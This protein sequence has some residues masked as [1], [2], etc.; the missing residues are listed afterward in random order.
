MNA[1]SILA[2]KKRKLPQILSSAT[3]AK[4]ERLK[5]NAARRFSNRMQGE[6]LRGKG[7]TSTEFADYRSYTAGDDI[8]NVDWNI[9]SRLRKPYVKQFHVE[10]QTQITILIDASSSM[11]FDGKFERAREIA[12][13]IGIMGL[14]NQERVAAFAWGGEHGPLPALTP[15]AGRASLRKLLNFCEGIEGGG[16]LAIEQGVEDMLYQIKGRGIILILSD[17]LTTGELKPSFN[18]LYANGLEIMGLQILSPEEI[19]PDLTGDVRLIDCETRGELDISSAG[20]LINLYQEYREGYAKYLE[21][22]CRQRSGR[23][24]TVSSHDT[25]EQIVF[26]QMRRKGWVR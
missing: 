6:N 13:A 23:F 20:N 15:C 5:V 19:N 8:R 25:V 12:A 22:L 2:D 26:E 11:M 16:D 3:M 10:E 1:L 17:F 24:M 7:G 9:F 14:F 18:R 4:A 21:S